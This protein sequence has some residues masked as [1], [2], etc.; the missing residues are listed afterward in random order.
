MVNIVFRVRIILLLLFLKS[1][2][3]SACIKIEN[4]I[5]ENIISANHIFVG[6]VENYI[7]VDK[8]RYT[9][10]PR[11]ALITFS[12]EEELFGKHDS[13][14]V[15][16]FWTNSTF[17]LPGQLD[18]DRYLVA[19]AK[20]DGQGIIETQYPFKLSKLEGVLQAPCTA[21]FLLKPSVDN[22]EKAKK[23]LSVV[24][25]RQMK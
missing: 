3:V 16:L 11:H 9:G 13:S 19:S 2:A 7:V 21:P 24:S 20:V 25:A 4:F 10:M 1:S 12:V 5:F 17:G 22:I 23:A 8:N 6:K 18:E 14:I 15:D